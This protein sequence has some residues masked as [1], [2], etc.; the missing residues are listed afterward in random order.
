MNYK[1]GVSIVPTP[2]RGFMSKALR[3]VPGLEK[4]AMEVLTIIII[5]II[6]PQLPLWA[7]FLGDGR[8]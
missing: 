1:V 8:W 3:T 2:W 7:P 4:N 6:V 5:I